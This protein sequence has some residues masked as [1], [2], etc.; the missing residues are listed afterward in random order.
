MTSI[1]YDKKQLTKSSCVVEIHRIWGRIAF[2]LPVELKLR[3]SN[4]R[5]MVATIKIRVGY[6]LNMLLRVRID[7]IHQKDFQPKSRKILFGDNCPRG[8]I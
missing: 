6:R 7:Q 8:L 5:L 2:A 4:T 3:P 1:H